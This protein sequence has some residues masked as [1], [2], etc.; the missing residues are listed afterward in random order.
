M[1]CLRSLSLVP[2]FS[3]SL[4]A[5][6]S[7]D[8]PTPDAER[9]KHLE[10]LREVAGSIRVLADP[11]KADS[12]V[13]LRK[14]PVLRY[15]DST[16]ATLES[17]LW[18][19][20]DGGRPAAIMAIEYYPKGPT[21]PRWLYEIASL[22]TKRIAAER[23]G[24]FEW[25]AKEGLK[26]ETLADAPPPAEKE[27]RRLAQMKDLRD[28]FTAYENATGTGRLELRPLATPLLR[29]SAA[30][31]GLVDGA[32]FSF[33]NG[34]NPEVFLVLEASGKEKP[35]WQFA[36][37]QMTGESV[38][39]QL[40]GKEIWKQEGGYPPTVRASYINGWI[41]VKGEGK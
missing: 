30:K 32:I 20:S 3:I 11:K 25:T 26:F 21:G 5:G 6:A 8:E 31:E 41:E 19:W 24:S 33:A 35:V 14:D 16:R 4:L 22:S 28:R 38:T 15:A 9:A 27:T 12:A 10:R 40:D 18:I 13:K 29:Y 17:T 36:L 7:A 34:T 37:V 1:S 2:L 23:E 39:A